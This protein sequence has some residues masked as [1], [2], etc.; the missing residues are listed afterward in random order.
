MKRLA[1]VRVV[2]ALAAIGSAI[3][4]DTQ[5]YRVVLARTILQVRKNIMKVRGSNRVVI[6]LARHRRRQR[7]QHLHA[8]LGAQ[9]PSAI[10]SIVKG[11]PFVMHQSRRLRLLVSANETCR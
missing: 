10:G 1:T 8:S 11:A 7:Q 4:T 3:L 9:W 2:N 6:A 5:I